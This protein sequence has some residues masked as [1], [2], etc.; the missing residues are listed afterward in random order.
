MKVSSIAECGY[1]VTQPIVTTVAT[2]KFESR[3]TSGY[4]QF[5]VGNQQLVWCNFVKDTELT[6]DK[7]GLSTLMCVLMNKLNSSRIIP[8]Q[9]VTV[10]LLGLSL[11]EC[12][13]FFDH[14]SFFTKRLSTTASR[15]KP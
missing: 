11:V 13:E 15:Q 10:I 2:I 8:L 1:D 5:I 3:T 14:V 4:I 6:D 12:T 9:E 7:N